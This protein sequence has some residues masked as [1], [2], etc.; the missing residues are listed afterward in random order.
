MNADR[1][2]RRMTQAQGPREDGEMMFQRFFKSRPAVEAGRSLYMPLIEQARSPVFYVEGKAADTVDGRFEL[3]TL[4]LALIVRRLRGAGPFAAEASQALF[5]TF[6]SG[7]DDGLREMG[8]G[9]LTVPKKMRKLGEA[10][11]GRMRNLDAALAEGA[12]PEGLEDLLTR[13]VYSSIDGAP[14]AA[15]ARYVRLADAALTETDEAAL[16]DGLLSWPA[17][18]FKGCAALPAPGP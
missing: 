16:F 3:Y 2:W 5:E 17:P 7:L 8:V 9:D 11:Y 6:L 15:L 14:V 18:D 13:T 4:H 1:G 10:V 12:G